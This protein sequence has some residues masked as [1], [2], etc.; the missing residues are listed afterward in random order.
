M[1][2]NVQHNIMIPSKLNIRF[3]G[4]AHSNFFNIDGKEQFGDIGIMMSNS[5]IMINSAIGIMTSSSA[6][7]SNSVICIM[8]SNSVTFSLHIRN[9][10]QK[11]RGEMGWVLRVLESGIHGSKIHTNHQGFSIQQ[12]VTNKITEEQHL[13]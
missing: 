5:A 3:N 8:M 6:K 4:I 7:M 13:N 2:G 12:T 9:L 10:V 11:S 1:Q